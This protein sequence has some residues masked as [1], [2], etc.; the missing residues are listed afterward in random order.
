MTATHNKQVLQEVFA[1]TAKGNGRPF[2]AAMAEDV[3]WTI[4]G[5]T[6]WSKT[7]RGK[8]AV[9]AELLGPLN[10]QLANGNT[11]TAHRFIAEDDQVVVEG[12]GHNT[13]KT[14]KAYQNTY[15]WVFR[16]SGGQVVDIVEYTDT[17]LIE[18]A[19]LPPQTSSR[20]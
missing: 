12:R 3:T 8:K 19:L 6:Q 14:G 1:E 16:L 17:A 15:C 11:I 20:T 2:V 5:S 10:A 4:I 9:L 7:Y 13:T 18:S